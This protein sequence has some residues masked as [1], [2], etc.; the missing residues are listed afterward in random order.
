MV[1]DEEGVEGK[2]RMTGSAPMSSRCQGVRQVDTKK[3]SSDNGDRF[4]DERRTDSQ[5]KKSNNQ[6][7]KSRK[8]S[9]EWEMEDGRRESEGK[10]DESIGDGWMMA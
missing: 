4:K 1:C 6:L 3:T 7:A 2:E 9:W 10:A 8:E 5:G